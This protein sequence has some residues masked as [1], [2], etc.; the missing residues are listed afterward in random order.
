MVLVV[1]GALLWLWPTK[2]AE[3]TNRL[4]YMPYRESAPRAA[5]AAGAAILVV[6][7]VVLVAT[8]L[9]AAL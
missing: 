5:R 8:A 4:R 2:T 1:A 6:G 9:V 7:A 3:F